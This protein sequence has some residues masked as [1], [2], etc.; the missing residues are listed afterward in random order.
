MLEKYKKLQVPILKWYI[1]L[2]PFCD[3]IYTL[4][5]KSGLDLP[6]N[7]NQIIRFVGLLIMITFIRDFTDFAKVCI[8]GAWMAICFFMQ[9]GMNMNYGTMSNFSY[10]LKILNGAIFMYAFYSIFKNSVMEVEKLEKYIMI[11]GLISITSVLLSYVGLGFESYGADA[12]RWGVKGLFSIQTTITGFLLMVLPLFALRKDKKGFI[13]FVLCVV[14]LISIG[15][16]TGVLGT[17]LVV[18][19]ILVYQL[20][21]NPKLVNYVK[22]NKKKFIIAACIIGPILLGGLVIYIIGLVELYY[23]KSYYTSLVSFILSNRASQLYAI[24][25]YMF[26]F[27]GSAEVFAGALCGYGFTYANYMMQYF[28]LTNMMAIEMDFYGLYFY[29]GLPVM[30]YFLWNYVKAMGVGI[31]GV[32]KSRFNDYRLFIYV[33]IFGVGLVYAA[34]GGHVLYEA[35][36]QLPFYYACGY[37]LYRAKSVEKAQNEE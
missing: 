14:A 8:L 18:V 4:Y 2:Y 12:G 29:S 22:C 36:T 26:Q 32:F 19:V 15:S 13:G 30:F 27:M 34:L 11:S 31:K 10:C 37:L 5:T 33:L 35:L 23:A 17:A 24:L 9:I 3:I 7:P 20:F 28:G 16:K 21:K 1:I 25:E 6:V